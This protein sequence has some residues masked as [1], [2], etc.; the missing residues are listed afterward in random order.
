MTVECVNCLW[1]IQKNHMECVVG[2]GMMVGA[3]HVTHSV[4]RRESN[5]AGFL[6]I[7]LV[8]RHP[9]AAKGKRSLQYKEGTSL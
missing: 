3:L 4:S 8:G 7:E 1:S 5:S 2:V 6:K 9:H